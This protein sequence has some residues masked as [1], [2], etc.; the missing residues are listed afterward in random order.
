[1]R[2]RLGALALA[3][4]LLLAGS[5]AI[6]KLEA[7]GA[8]P[9][10]LGKSKDGKVSVSQF[11]GR[12][13]VVTFWASWCGP[14]RRELPVLDA[15]KQVA[16][17][18][19]EVVAVNVKDSVQDYNAIKRQLKGTQIIFTHD[20]YGRIADSYKVESF[21]NLYVIDQSGKI[22]SVH[23]GFGEDS[24]Q[25]IVDDINKLLVKPAA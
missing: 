14:C 4:A 1:M 8:P 15:L 25:S 7:G 17:D 2:R 23:I 6:A 16:G 21:P 12:V 11:H 5:D 20:A 24:L 13:V 9:D 10:D 3:C 19:A 22:A 18:R